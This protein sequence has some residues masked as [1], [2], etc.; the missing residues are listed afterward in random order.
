MCCFIFYARSL[1]RQAGLA[2]RVR[3][4]Y[5]AVDFV[6]FYDERLFD[7]QPESRKFQIKNAVKTNLFKDAA[8]KILR[9][10]LRIFEKR[11]QIDKPEAV[12]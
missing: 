8:R 4:D 12:C 11:H 6:C 3:R 1:Q 10:A 7:A 2:V 5:L 9:A